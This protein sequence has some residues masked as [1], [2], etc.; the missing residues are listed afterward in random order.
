MKRSIVLGVGSFAYGCALT[1]CGFPYYTWQ[2]WLLMPLV[3][4]WV[5]TLERAR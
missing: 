2:F 3:V 5:L 4:A 1:V